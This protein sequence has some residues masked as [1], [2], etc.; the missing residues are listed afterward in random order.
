VPV[1]FA[2]APEGPHRKRV[3]EQR[4]LPAH[5]LATGL[6]AAAPI[7]RMDAG[8]DAQALTPVTESA[9]LQEAALIGKHS[10]RP[11][12]RSLARG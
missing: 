5:P 10:R 11:D 7:F 12:R 9:Y 8:P 3:V 1:D 6:S 2:A 4:A